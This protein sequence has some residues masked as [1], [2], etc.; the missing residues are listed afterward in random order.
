MTDNNNKWRELKDQGNEFLDHPTTRGGRIY[1]FFSLVLIFVTVFEVVL[2]AKKPELVHQYS[3]LFEFV[4]HSILFFFS[5]DL[6]LRLLVYKD[7]FKY[8]FSFYGM[9]DVIAVVPGLVGLFIPLAGSTSWVRILRIF[10]VGRVLR[11]ASTSGIFGGFNGLLMPYIAGA[12]G[13]KSLVLVLEEYQ[14]WPEIQDLG[15]VL[16]VLGFALAVLLGAKL[17]LVNSR[18]YSIE[19]AVCR[20][21]GA[22]GL[23]RSNE[24]IKTGV[25]DWATHFE[26][27]IR[28]PTKADVATMRVATD[29]LTAEFERSSVAGPNVSG[30]GRDVAYVLHRVTARSPIAY[31]KFLEYV[32]FT[33]TMIVVLVVPGITGFLAS[34][35]TVYILLGMYLLIDDMD[36][37]LEYS[38]DSLI[39]VDLNPL[40]AF[41]QKHST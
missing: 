16:G 26:E 12:I 7:K 8:L 3:V 19:D 4:E 18:I 39:T 34:I 31:E 24:D 36:R 22:L 2:A 25:S 14:W 37:P 21:V 41:N 15:V 23:M 32:T 20:I 13:F 35:L 17:Q 5:V 9:V 10:R 30:F 38:D 1:A 29:D 6:V 33:Y 11:T 28:N 27:I 40:I